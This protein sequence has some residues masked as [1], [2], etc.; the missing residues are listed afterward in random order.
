MFALMC[1]PVAR[2]AIA[3]ALSGVADLGM[4][5][6]AL[7]ADEEEQ[8]LIGYRLAV[9]GVSIIVNSENPICSLTRQQV[10]QLLPAKSQTGPTSAATM[11]GRHR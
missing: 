8:G 3:D 7:K 10:V 6:R 2:T 5:S 4:A 9:D 11:R 1:R